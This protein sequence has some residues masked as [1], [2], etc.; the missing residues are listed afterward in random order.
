MGTATWLKAIAN[1]A[2]KCHL[3]NNV[4]GAQSIYCRSGQDSVSGQI[5]GSDDNTARAEAELKGEVDSIKS[6]LASAEKTLE[7]INGDVSDAQKQLAQM[8][9]DKASPWD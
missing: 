8:K 7:Q 9:E 1:G 2:Y 6:H 5:E 4:K 3:Y